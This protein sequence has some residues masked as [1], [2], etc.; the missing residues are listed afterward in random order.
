[1]QL[2]PYQH[3]AVESIVQRG[4]LLLAMT[5]GS[6]KTATAIASVRKLRQ[7]R[8]AS[9]GIVF[10]L[11]STKWQW[12]R[13]IERWDPR[14]RVQV[15]DGDKA[16]RIRGY[17]HAWRYHYTILHYQCLIHDWDLIIK[18]LPLDF[19][20]A[21]EVTAF[22][23]FA[24][25]TSRRGKQLAKRTDIRMGLSGQPVENRPE[26]L[27]SI[28]EFVDPDVLGGFHK[29][30]RCFIVRDRWGKPL[31]YRNLYLLQERM[32]EAMFRRSREDIAEWLPERIEIE[33]PVPLEPAVMALH[34]L[35]RKDL[36]LAID[37]AI[38]GGA[39]GSFD[40]LAHY[41]R[42]AQGETISLMGQVM[43][44]L[45]AMRMLSSHPRL[46]R[47]SADEFDTE[48]SRRGSEYASLLKANGLLNNLP[49]STAK[50]DALVELVT[51]I[52]DEDPTHKVVV[53]SYFKPMLAM[54][55]Q[56]MPAKHVMITGD[57]TGRM[58]DQAIV[59]FNNDPTVRVFLS[60]D[61]GAY[62][63]DL[64]QGSHLICYDLPW[65]AGA[66]Q[67]R[68]SRID[69]TNSAFPTI[70]I[71]YMYGQDTIEERMYQ[72]LLQKAKVARAFL[73][74]EFD[75]KGIL[76]LDLQSLRDFLDAA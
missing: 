34:D 18:Y 75:A 13:E 33:V 56:L 38:A 50:L 4:N 23:G 55:A 36:S 25:K 42:V 63:V 10:A 57:V 14:A 66:L 27:F 7:Q 37:Q 48:V 64:N 21:D 12:V 28:M 16:Q 24:T 59:Q 62:G 40:V 76:K 69:R 8:R 72:M 74:G 45:L 39:H 6:G 35:V 29:F 11:K 44:R 47:L 32:G 22:K 65:S 60:S 15:I 5:M 20:I 26:E 70:N 68:V 9:H 46:L 3:D 43:S 41:G 19:I 17:K 53:F 2:R 49:P 61:A 31:R 54:I 58:R 73:D 52:L 51:Q 30:D 67:Q 1:M 71:M